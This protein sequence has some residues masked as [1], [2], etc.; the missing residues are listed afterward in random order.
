MSVVLRILVGSNN[1][2]K[3]GA[4]HKAFST[5]FPDYSIHS[6]GM[7]A[8][9]NVPDQPMT[10]LDTRLGA[11]NRTAYCEQSDKE[12]SYDYYVAM[13]GGVDKFSEGP[14]TFAYI[15]IRGQHNEQ[16]ARRHSVGRSAN[17]PLPKRI[18]ERL[19][20]GEELGHVMD[21]VFNQ[22]NIKQKGGAIGLL[23]N[24]L[25]TRESI[26]IDAITLALAPY[27]HPEHYL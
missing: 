2:V 13:E 11:E 1:P 25:A 10:E 5:A 3:I 6:E 17:L 7:N 22:T 19:Q 27:F 21:D 9:S 15:S 18:Y 8:P 12:R 26:Y 4:A 14:A 16:Q 20:A 24:H 23:T